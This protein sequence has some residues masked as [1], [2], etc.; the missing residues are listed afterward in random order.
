[1]TMLFLYH[2]SDSLWT[3]LT[4]NSTSRAQHTTDANTQYP[5]NN[6]YIRLRHYNRILSSYDVEARDF[7]Y[8]KHHILQ[9]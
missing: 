1:M 5:T 4:L 3:V 8:Q 9:V 6:G 2:L 7:G